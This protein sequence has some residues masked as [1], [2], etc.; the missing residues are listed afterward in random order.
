M[1]SLCGALHGPSGVAAL[2]R[3]LVWMSAAE[4]LATKQG[5]PIACVASKCNDEGEEHHSKV[6]HYK[7][8]I[9]PKEDVEGIVS[10]ESNTWMD[11]TKW[12]PIYTYPSAIAFR[13][14]EASVLD[15][16]GNLPEEGYYRVRIK[17]SSGESQYS[18]VFVRRG[19]KFDS[20]DMEEAQRVE[21]KHL[22]VGLIILAVVVIAAALIGLY[23]QHMFK[24]N[25]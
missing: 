7:L 10:L 13:G 15:Y 24:I 8:D 1:V 21:R 6:Q 9:T 23:I 4:S 14:G 16:R 19:D 25:S 18:G 5:N 3:M 2:L 17:T 20:V 12:D 22:S 11:P